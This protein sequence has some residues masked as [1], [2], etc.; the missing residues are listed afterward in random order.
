M[1]RPLV[2]KPSREF[3]PV[4]AWAPAVVTVKIEVRPIT[5]ELAAKDWPCRWVESCC[6]S[7]IPGVGGWEFA[8]VFE[9]ILVAP[10]VRFAALCM[11]PCRCLD[12]DLLCLGV[13]RGENAD[14]GAEGDLDVVPFYVDAACDCATTYDKDNACLW[15]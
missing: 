12:N 7:H 1:T 6:A 9:S 3:E 11:L 5:A 2:S 4:T 14:L 8:F 13:E 10:L 15:V